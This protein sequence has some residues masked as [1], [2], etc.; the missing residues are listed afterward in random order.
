M[1][2]IHTLTDKV[3][4]FKCLIIQTNQINRGVWPE[5]ANILNVIIASKNI[6]IKSVLPL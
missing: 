6:A 3:P 1:D 4:K 5:L 2:Y